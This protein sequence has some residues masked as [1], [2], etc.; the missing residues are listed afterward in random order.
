MQRKDLAG[1]TLLPSFMDSHSHLTALAQTMGLVNL[2][3][4]TS[5]SEI[6]TKLEQYRKT[7]NIPK[8]EWIVGFGYD[9]NFLAEKRHPNKIDL[10]DFTENPILLAHVSGHM[11]VTNALGLE[12]MKI[13]KNT[14][15]PEGGKIGKLSNGEVS[16]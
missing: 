4:T 9:H 5:I 13:E 1:K 8:G 2:R 15:N 16:G 3:E 6:V 10:K 11:G 7:R 12:Q 14:P